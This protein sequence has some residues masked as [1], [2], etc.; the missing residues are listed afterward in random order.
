MVV[1]LLRT[2]RFTSHFFLSLAVSL[3]VIAIDQCRQEPY[4]LDICTPM[5]NHG[6]KNCDH[7]SVKYILT[8]QVRKLEFLLA[9]ALEKRCDSVITCGGIQS[10]HAR[11]TAVASRELGLQPHLVLRWK[12]KI[13]C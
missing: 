5:S 11:A 3:A 9:E 8:F 10:N 1:R 13:V 6:D 12:G 2:Q 7:A 4:D